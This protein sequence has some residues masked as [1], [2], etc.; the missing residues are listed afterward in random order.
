MRLPACEKDESMLQRLLGISDKSF[1]GVERPPART[2][3]EHCRAGEVFVDD[4][5][6][7][8]AFAIVIDRGGPYIWSIAVVS[9]LRKN[10]I[11][12]TL[13][14]EIED[15]YRGLASATVQLTCRIENWQ[16]QRVYLKMGYRVVRVV[17]RYYGFEDG[18]LM[19]RVL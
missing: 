7:P 14:K 8:C 15:Y 12:S 17:P 3:K 13:L 5:L 11:G 10:G 4:S 18:L 1:D 9:G 2:F 16:A 19:R 6:T